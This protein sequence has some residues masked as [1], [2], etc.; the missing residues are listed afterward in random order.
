MRALLL[1]PLVLSVST[2]GIVHSAQPHPVRSCATLHHAPIPGTAGAAV[3][4]ARMQTGTRSAR[5]LLTP[6][7]AIH[8]TVA[9]NVHRVRWTPQDSLLRARADSVLAALS[10]GLTVNRRDSTLHAV[11]DS[12]ESPH[13]LYAV[14][15]GE[16]LEAARAHLDSIGMR[17]PEYASASTVYNAQGQGRYVVDIAD[18]GNATGMWGPNY[19]ITR[20]PSS[21]GSIIVENDFLYAASY[22]PTTGEVTGTPLRPFIAGEFRNY[23]VEW[24]MGLRVT[25][26][27]E[28]Y[29]AVQF[30]YTPSLPNPVH[31]WYELTAVGM[32]ERLAPGINDYFQYLPSILPD[33]HAV[34]VLNPLDGSFRN[35]GNGI[36]HMFLSHNL[37]PDFDR[38]IW[39]ALEANGNNLPAALVAGLGSQARWDSLFTAYA[40]AM[41][42]AGTPA[43]GTSPLAFTPGMAQWPRPRLEETPSSGT[44]QLTLPPG[45]YRIV[46][47]SE[48]GRYWVGIPE[49]S[50]AWRVSSAGQEALFLP[51]PGVPLQGAGNP[52]LAVANSAFPGGNARSMTISPGGVGLSAQPNPAGG[53]ATTVEFAT[54]QGVLSGPLT[55]VSE[56]GRRVATLA[57]DTASP[58]WN[59]DLRDTTGER[60]PPG[61]YLFRAPGYGA[62]PLLVTP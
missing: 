28:F 44:T 6:N 42:L 29:H 4:S 56:T 47:A 34:N 49:I 31:A 22:Q 51:G 23:N 7:F 46:P 50:G 55:V 27:H 10:P 62:Q 38:P 16:Y 1:I 48:H 25:I 36:F 40:A 41:T 14:R 59:W 20:A 60:V 15:A 17:L 33:N 3:L 26:A 53:Q 58:R 43:A 52:V 12:M 8:Y 19:G 11:L 35:Y 24:D 32:E 39:E 18:M 9:P 45:T 57:P 54:G 30:A 37:G 2:P 21:G 5:T 13:P 61:I